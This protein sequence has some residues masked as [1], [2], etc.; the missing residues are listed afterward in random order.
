MIKVG[1]DLNVCPD[2]A[3]LARDVLAYIWCHWVNGRTEADTLLY[4]T[5]WVL[6]CRG[7]P[8]GVQFSGICSVCPS[9]LSVCTR[10]LLFLD[11]LKKA[12]V[13]A[14]LLLLS[15]RGVTEVVLQGVG[16]TAIKL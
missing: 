14:V 3:G 1:N 15:D 12:M 11:I 4:C 2:V 8:T 13:R 7:K 9:D 6:S 16:D 10:M 5:Q